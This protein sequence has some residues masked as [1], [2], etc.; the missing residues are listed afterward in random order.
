MVIDEFGI[1]V[2]P[3]IADDHHVEIESGVIAKAE[4]GKDEENGGNG[5]QRDNGHGAEQAGLLKEDVKFR[6]DRGNADE[7]CAA[8]YNVKI[9][10]ERQSKNDDDADDSVK[11]GHV[12]VRLRCKI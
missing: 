8:N 11:A 4:F 9:K 1:G 3:E 7:R 12:E 5:K 2:Q 10:Q 6:I